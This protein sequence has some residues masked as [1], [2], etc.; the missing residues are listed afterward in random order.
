MEIREVLGG[1]VTRA[2]DSGKLEE[3]ALP[4]LLHTICG[5]QETGVLRL[6]R[7]GVSKAIYIKG[8]KIVFA[9]ST[10]KDDRLGELLLRRG[11]LRVQ[12]LENA[13]ACFPSPKRLG[14]I[15]VEMGYIKPEALVWGVIEQVKEIVFGLFLW[16]DGE[17]HFERGPLPSQEVITLNLSTPQV[18]VGGIQRIDRWWQV[19]PAL[20]NLDSVYQAKP[21]HEAIFK[22]M[23]LDPDQTAI[24]R[25]LAQP[26]TVRDLCGLGLLPD[27]ETCRMLWAFRVIGVVETTEA[28][29]CQPKIA[30]DWGNALEET[31]VADAFDQICSDTGSAAAPGPA[32]S[33]SESA[34]GQAQE[35]PP[36][37]SATAAV[38][39][40]PAPGD[41]GTT[42]MEAIQPPSADAGATVMEAIQPPSADAGTTVME[43]IQPP[44]ADAGTTV[45]KAIQMPGSDVAVEDVP[46]P[47]PE[48]SP[49]EVEPAAPDLQASDVAEGGDAPA[50]PAAKPADASLDESVVDAALFAFSARHRRLH[51]LL[52]EKMG[53][54]APALIA[55]SL[56]S[57]AKEMPALFQDVAASPDGSL[58]TE[59]LKAN[60]LS[61]KLD[62]FAAVLDMLIDRELESVAANLGAAARREIVTE[63]K[64]LTG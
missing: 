37:A 59:I 8:G 4:D 38:A 62:Y 32:N 63:M 52:E 49:P 26:T 11:L 3:Q 48:V 30:T 46:G 2:E 13:L 35:A 64:D 12:Q 50:A 18:I 54:K 45:M 43:A 20:G 24:L 5:L 6:E 58:D 27:F 36:M 41:A 7:R 14:T 33:A 60:I 15:L 25:L 51:G 47:S 40:T 19:L 61:A 28:P 57:M 9:S 10:E 34:V 29:A 1:I 53:D 56:K 31:A 42:V 16:S 22:Q 17:Y 44:S 23:K 39:G 55:R 21:G